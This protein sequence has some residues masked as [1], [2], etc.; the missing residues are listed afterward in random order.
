MKNKNQ[1]IEEVLNCIQQAT[2]RVD[3][4]S[5]DVTLVAVSK[6]H[7][8]EDIVVAYQAGIR[9]FGENR[10]DELAKKAIQLSHLKDLQWHFIGHLQTR[11]SK[12][13]AEYAHCFHAVD[14]VKIA[15]H[16]SK[17]LQ[18]LDHILP[19]FIE[20][21]VSGE[22]S[23]G[24]FSCDDWEND[25]Q[26]RDSFLKAVTTI[27]ALP[28]LNIHGL[29]AMAPFKASKELIRNIFKSLHQLSEWLN[30]E[31]PELKA[32]ELSMGMSGDFEIAVE[33]GATHV[34][35][36]SAIFGKRGSA[37]SPKP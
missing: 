22:K 4:S 29:M 16:L 23:K 6:T 14:R 2:D 19:V 35:V 10:A 9:H 28:N 11:Q 18:K 13:V 33:E 21:N 27:A 34:R 17:Q 36:G 15:E 8:I 5:N 25:Q 3:R 32:K 7:P 24:G 37:I 26:Q 20:V 31:L 30:R 1:L 12:I